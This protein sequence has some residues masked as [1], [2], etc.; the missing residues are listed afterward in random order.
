[1]VQILI[2]ALYFLFGAITIW[3]FSGLIV[4]AVDRVAQR[5]NKSGFTVAFFV[6]GFMTSIS[7]ISVLLN[8]T[9]NG[10]PQVSAGNLPGASLVILAFIVPVL[11]IVGNGISLQGN[12]ARMQFALCLGVILLPA[13]FLTDG[14]VTMSEGLFSIFSYCAIAYLLKRHSAPSIPTLVTEVEKELQAKRPGNLKD[15]SIILIGAI[16]IFLSGH[17]IVEEAMYFSQLLMIPPSIIG[18]L[19]LSI[20]TNMPEIVIAFRSLKKQKT[21][22]AFGDY[23]GSAVTNTLLFGLLSIFNGQFTVQTS[24]FL[25]TLLFMMAGFSLLFIFAKSHNTISR[26]EGMIILS[27]YVLFLIVQVVNVGITHVV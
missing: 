13:L 27:C 12:V 20:G 14:V 18:L 8:S 15:G 26:S 21:D 4:D 24:E 19:V 7:E 22:I 3:Y 16:A 9:L 2:H 17:I 23:I 25:Y 6:L 1:M 10:V 11:A 5:L